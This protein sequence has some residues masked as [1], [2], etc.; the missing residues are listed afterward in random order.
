MLFFLMTTT[1]GTSGIH[2]RCA[3][4]GALV[5]RA[6]F[7]GPLREHGA[8]VRRAAVSPSQTF[9]RAPFSTRLLRNCAVQFL[10]SQVARGKR[11]LFLGGYYGSH[12]VTRFWQV[13]VWMLFR[14]AGHRRYCG[15]D[16]A[17]GFRT[18]DDLA[19]FNAFAFRLLVVKTKVVLSTVVWN[20]WMLKC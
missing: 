3:A 18:A 7:S 2:T 16:S 6:P 9:R 12:N 15:L 1:T 13:V 5:Q 4:G 8:L 20:S 11:Q 19:R 17:S 10:K 14:V